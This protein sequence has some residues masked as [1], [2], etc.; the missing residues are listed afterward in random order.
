MVKAIGNN[1]FTVAIRIKVDAPGRH[2]A[3]Q[4]RAKAFEECAPPFDFVH[5]EK[6]LE[7][8]A[9]VK[10]CGSAGREVCVWRYAMAG[11]VG[12]ELRLVKVG[13]QAG[14]K[15]VERGG[16]G[17]CCHASD[18]ERCQFWTSG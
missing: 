10:K 12:E 13:L 4:I 6:D 11:S 17:G 5:A 18:T 16:Q 15:D 7:G 2:H 8:F 9:E 14:F 1:P 3:D